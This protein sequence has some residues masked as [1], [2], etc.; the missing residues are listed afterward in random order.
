M[1]IFSKPSPIFLFSSNWLVNYF[2]SSAIFIR[3]ALRTLI[4]SSLSVMF[5]VFYLWWG[6]NIATIFPFYSELLGVLLLC[7][8]FLFFSYDRDLWRSFFFF[9]FLI[10]LPYLWCWGV[11]SESEMRIGYYFFVSILILSFPILKRSSKLLLLS[12]ISIGSM[13]CP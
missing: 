11:S 9:F 12:S 4:W 7:L 1:S 3:L 13:V 6:S 5:I 8:C 2:Y 10:F